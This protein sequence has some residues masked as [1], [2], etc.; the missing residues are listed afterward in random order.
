M[1]DIESVTLQSYRELVA[2]MLWKYAEDEV[3]K[4]RRKN[5]EEN[6]SRLVYQSKRSDWPEGACSL[7]KEIP[8]FSGTCKRCG[9]APED[10]EYLHTEG[11]A[12]ESDFDWAS[13]IKDQ[14]LYRSIEVLRVVP[15]GLVWEFTGGKRGTIKD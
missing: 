6:H 13:R 15:N 4:T 9:W 2:H 3:C 1:S 14:M 7:Y 5:I 12:E 10:H 11:D 8:G